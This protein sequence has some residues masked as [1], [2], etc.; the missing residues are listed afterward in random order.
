MYIHYSEKIKHKILVLWAPGWA[1]EVLWEPRYERLKVQKVDLFLIFSIF[2]NIL[3]YENTK[4]IMFWYYNII[5]LEYYKTIMFWYYNI[6]I[7]YRSSFWKKHLRVNFMG[8]F[9][10]VAFTS[11]SETKDVQTYG[12]VY[13]LGY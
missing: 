5:I 9:L 1:P 11:R 12:N 3:R 8:L 2:L 4:T 7:S 13:S 10:R 6:T